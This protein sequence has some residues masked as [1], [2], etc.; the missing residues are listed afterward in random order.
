MPTRTPAERLD[1]ALDELLIDDQAA[2]AGDLRPLLETASKVRAALRPLPVAPRFEERLAARLL[3]GSSLAGGL[4]LIAAVARQELR[5]PSRALL[6]GA[7]SSAAL[8]I[9][10]TAIVVWRGSRRHPSEPSAGER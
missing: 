8:G 4:G 10:L 7:V 9:G 2:V 5:H 3:Q 1:Q 6:T